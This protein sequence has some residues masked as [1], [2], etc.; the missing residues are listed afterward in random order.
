MEKNAK[1]LRSTYGS[2]KTEL[3]NIYHFDLYKLFRNGRVVDGTLVCTKEE[4]KSALKIMPDQKNYLGFDEKGYCQLF[5][6][7]FKALKDIKPIEDPKTYF[8]DIFVNIDFKKFI[9]TYKSSKEFINKLNTIENGIE[10]YVN[11]KKIHVVD[12]LKSNSMSKECCVYYVNKE[13]FDLIYP[14]ISFGMDK[15][16]FLLSKWYAYSGLSISDAVILDDIKIKEG[17]LV[18]I[19]DKERDVNVDCITAISIDYFYDL[20]KSYI[21]SIDGLKKLT[22]KSIEDSSYDDYLSLTILN[23]EVASKCLHQNLSRLKKI[24]K[25]LDCYIKSND[26]KIYQSYLDIEESSSEKSLMEVFN[27]FSNAIFSNY[28]L[29]TVKN[30]LVEEIREPYADYISGPHEVYWAKFNV[31]NFP[32]SVNKFDGEG[33]MSKEFCQLINSELKKKFE[34]NQTLKFG[35]TYQIRLPFIKGI[36]NSCDIKEF[37]KS[38]GIT[39]IWGKTFDED[40]TKSLRAYDINKVKIILTESQFK[41]ASFM[42]NLECNE[43]EQPIDAFMRLLEEYDYAFG[44]NNLEQK[45][46][47]TINMNYQFFSTI[48]FSKKSIDY[49]VKY[50]EQCYKDQTTQKELAKEMIK[51]SK[52]DYEKQMYEKYFNFYCSTKKYKDERT[53]LT[54][55]FKKGLLKLKLKIRG[56]RKFICGDLLELLYYSA[57]HNCNKRNTNKPLKVNECYTPHSIF[58]DGEKC[59][60]LRNPHYSRNEIAVLKNTH[61]KNTERR[62]YFGHLTGV[63]MYNPISLLAERLGGADFDGDTIVVLP[64]TEMLETMDALFTKHNHLKYPIIKIPGLTSTKQSWNYYKKIECFHNTFNSRVGIISNNAFK[65]TFD[66]YSKDN[67]KDYDK[68]AYY[69]ILNGL[70]IDS[71]KKGI[72]PVMGGKVTNKAAEEFIR[73]K[74]SV[75]SFDIEHRYTGERMNDIIKK[76]ANKHIVFD[77][78]NEVLEFKPTSERSKTQT[79]LKEFENVTKEQVGNMI[80]IYTAYKFVNNRINKSRRQVIYN[81]SNEDDKDLLYK[82][83]CN[84]LNKNGV[85]EAYEFIINFSSSIDNPKECLYN[86]CEDP[87]YKYHYLKTYE[88]KVGF[89][90]TKLGLFGLSDDQLNVLCNFS[91]DGYMLLYLLICYL[92][93]ISCIEDSVEKQ[94][95]DQN[96]WEIVLSSINKL[97]KSF[98]F[99]EDEIEMICIK[100]KSLIESLSDEIDDL[101]ELDPKELK[102][103]EKI[104]S[105]KLIEKVKDIPFE[106][107]LAFK[108]INADN[109][110]FDVLAEKALDYLGKH[111][112]KYNG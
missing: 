12:F 44:I 104:V 97:D 107:Y 58:K 78:L 108:R 86:Y 73:L 16:K 100:A 41:C 15:G 70:E 52:N 72:K 32:S 92:N 6:Q 29:Q 89:I 37:F 48:P 67:T 102:Q 39:E 54:Q 106:A 64:Q 66:I 87:I 24:H 45:H 56:Q 82:T 26:Y 2:I 25:E 94:Y 60:L 74:D 18:V 93:N 80:Q 22:H 110:I 88:D 65:E 85:L 9:E 5:D 55:E 61:Q 57:Y 46:D 71:A 111:E 33:L 91:N 49:I 11:D 7:T 27:R 14:R 20:A 21:D 50:N 83:I 53:K 34:T 3:F 30:K 68:I 17:E 95:S 63:L 98:S 51:R 42:K 109:I 75:D 101:N 59:I 103:I 4:S 99:D 69:T 77:L 10:L 1:N 19:P 43:G 38:K 84:I 13:Y 36:I 62:K 81:F 105:T 76:N 47:S 31:K 23:D 112:E 35:F 79:R 28:P 40:K 8:V 96:I 90:E